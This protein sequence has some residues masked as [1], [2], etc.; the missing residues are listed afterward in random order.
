MNK[1]RD[2]TVLLLA[3][4]A[5]AASLVLFRRAVGFTSPW[6]G[7]TAMLS[8]L[9][10]VALARPLFLLKLPGFFR[11]NCEWE[12]RGRL[13]KAPGVQVF[14]ALLGRTPLRHLNQFV[15]LTRRGNL[16][17]V[18]AQIDSA[19]AAHILAAGLLIPHMVYACVQRW[20]GAVV[21]LMIVQLAVNLYPILHLRSV[22]VRIDR[23]KGR[24]P[25]RGSGAA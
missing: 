13:Y 11:R 21:W 20:W 17:M 1:L 8:A 5:F 24:K 23:F 9:G 3:A 10:L 14:G 4:I 19:E 18:Q 15:Y 12:A 22:R 2:L 6:F 16:S 25:S 7:L